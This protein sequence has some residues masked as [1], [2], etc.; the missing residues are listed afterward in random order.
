MKNK[1]HVVA[2]LDDGTEDSFYVHLTPRKHVESVVRSHFGSRLVK[3][4]L[5]E[6][7]G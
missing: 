3:I 5:V 7:I 4:L 6:S 1:W 2:L